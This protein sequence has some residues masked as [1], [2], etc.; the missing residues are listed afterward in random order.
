MGIPAAL[1]WATVLTSV[2]DLLGNPLVVAALSATLAIR[3]AP[4]IIGA[5]MKSTRGR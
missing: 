1:D 2:G 4:K 3:F 5:V